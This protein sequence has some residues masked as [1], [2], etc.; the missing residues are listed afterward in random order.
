MIH[1]SDRISPP[2]Q[3]NGS[4]TEEIHAAF[5]PADGVYLPGLTGGVR[6]MQRRQD[7]FARQRILPVIAVY[8]HIEFLK[9]P[10]WGRIELPNPQPE[11]IISLAFLKR[12]AASQPPINFKATGSV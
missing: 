5:G 6:A 9:H 2:C 12:R 4:R 10:G 11:D 8:F 3:L 7:A 1:G